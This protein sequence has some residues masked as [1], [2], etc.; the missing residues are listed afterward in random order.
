MLRRNLKFLAAAILAAALVTACAAAFDAGED[1]AEYDAQGNRLVTV[2]VPL[3]SAGRAVTT[4]VAKG[5]IDFYEVVFQQVNNASPA[6][7]TGKYYSAT[8]YKGVD[9]E[10]VLKIAP[11]NYYAVLFAGR[12]ETGDT[13]VLLATDI[14]YVGGTGASGGGGTPDVAGSPA[15][16]ISDTGGISNVGTG[17]TVIAFKLTTLDLAGFDGDTTK[18]LTLSGSPVSG[19]TPATA[20]AFAYSHYT[21]PL[22]SA[23]ATITVTFD[24]NTVGV[25]PGYKYTSG[26]SP[27]FKSAIDAPTVDFKIGGVGTAVKDSNEKEVTGFELEALASPTPA[28][29]AVAVGGNPEPAV[30]GGVLSFSFK[31]PDTAG[32]TNLGIDISVYAFKD[33]TT[34]NATSQMKAIKW[35]VRNG[36]DTR[37]LDTDTLTAENSGAGILIA[38]GVT[39]DTL[40]PVPVG[41]SY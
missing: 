15:F 32:V 18:K 24:T 35:H 13:A 14:Q 9:K 40:L 5:N 10:L 28:F 20:D 27:V 7:P 11:G 29:S 23:G 39:P 33:P 8:G 22:T 16:I 6:V 3:E 25:F 41:T 26:T 34:R 37:R 2:T 31:L 1:S 12:K 21:Y 4:A 36:L 38:L 17:A 19:K 30:D